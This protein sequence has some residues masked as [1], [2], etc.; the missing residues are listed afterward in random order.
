MVATAAA[1]TARRAEPVEL[2]TAEHVC[3]ALIAQGVSH[4]WAL[5]TLLASDGE[6]GHI[7]TLSRPLTYRAID[8][9]V[10]KGMVIRPTAARGRG[11]DR[12][13]LNATSAGKRATRQWLD[14]PVEHLRD[15]RTDLLVKL[16]LRERAGLATA[17]LLTRQRDAFAPTIDAL[18]EDGGESDVVALWRRESA[19][20]VRRFLDQALAPTGDGSGATVGPELRVSARN[21]VR[22]RA[23]VVQRRGLLANVKAV[24]DEGQILSATIT[25]E[26]ADDLDLAVGDSVLLLVKATEVMVAKHRG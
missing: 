25:R 13:L 21:Q 8:G 24:L 16:H 1:R 7:W 18:T 9:L 10:D 5:G 12:L 11:R 15:V 17:P 23:V 4:G 19:R 26:G 6:V 20:A 22:G 3:L 2:S 14:T